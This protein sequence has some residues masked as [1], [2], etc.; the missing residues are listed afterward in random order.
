METKAP[1]QKIIKV[2]S[3]L[4][5]RQKFEKDIFAKGFVLYCQED[6]KEWGA[7]KGCLLAILFFPLIFIKT[8][9]IKVTYVKKD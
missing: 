1:D 5:S 3:N 8:N 6:V 2:F 9:K 7:K 4:K